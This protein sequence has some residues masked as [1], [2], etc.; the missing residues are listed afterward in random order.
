VTKGNIDEVCLGFKR[1]TVYNA[2]AEQQMPTHRKG[3]LWKF[4]K[5]E[6]EGCVKSGGAEEPESK[7]SATRKKQWIF[8]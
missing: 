2:I 5:E 6:M 4:R 1:N 7:N 8:C 3:S